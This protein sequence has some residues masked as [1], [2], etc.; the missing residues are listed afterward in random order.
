MAFR[1][2]TLTVMMMMMMTTNEGQMFHDKCDFVLAA[3]VLSKRAGGG[4]CALCSGFANSGSKMVCEG[5]CPLL[6]WFKEAVS[7]FMM[8]FARYNRFMP[9]A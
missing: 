9:C 4:G 3:P 6:E 7:M 8:R 5:S 2:R 1:T